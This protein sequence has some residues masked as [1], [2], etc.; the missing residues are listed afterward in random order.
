MQ[1]PESALPE[2]LETTNAS[3][4]VSPEG[5]VKL[6]PD[7]GSP[8]DVIA[9][10]TLTPPNIGAAPSD[11]ATDVLVPEELQAPTI[12]EIG[13]GTPDPVGEVAPP[14]GWVPN[15]Q[16]DGS[17]EVLETIRSDCSRARHFSGKCNRYPDRL[18]D[19]EYQTRVEQGL[20]IGDGSKESKQEKD[21]LR[22]IFL[23]FAEANG[24]ESAQH[25]LDTIIAAME[26]FNKEKKVDILH[27]LTVSLATQ[28]MSGDDINTLY[29]KALRINA[30]HEKMDTAA[31]TGRRSAENSRNEHMRE[32][33]K[34]IPDMDYSDELNVYVQALG[35]SL[36]Q[37]FVPGYDILEN[38]DG[39]DHWGNY[40]GTPTT[41]DYVLESIAFVPVVGI[42][43]KLGKGAKPLL[44]IL[45]KAG[46][47]CKAHSF[48]ES[49]PVATASGLLAIG[50][51]EEQDVLQVY[52]YDEETDKVALFDITAFHVHDDPVTIDLTVDFDLTDDQPGELIETTP[53]HPFY[54]LGGWID[55]EDLEV[56]M[57]LSTFEGT[58][59]VHSSTVT[60]VERIEETQT[61]YNLTVDTAHTFFVGEGE[62]LVH[63]C[64]IPGFSRNVVGTSINGPT[65]G[66][67]IAGSS[68]YLNWVNTTGRYPSVLTTNPQSLIDDFHAGKGVVVSDTPGAKSAVVRFDRPIGNI[69]DPNTGNVLVEGTHYGAVKYGSRLHITPV[70]WSTP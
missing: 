36:A 43:G 7:V 48:S 65:Q 66:K 55:A 17:V 10:G 13:S 62:W 37:L 56:G 5:D 24:V 67:H 20:D 16:E 53:E 23:G 49:T 29:E 41:G 59:L 15:G 32:F 50:T 6:P 47:V 33:R 54:V 57:P 52:G 18:S 51:L 4:V 9:P 46:K 35:I 42:L 22:G 3:E 44:N 61:M 68:E 21:K 34:V 63:N 64:D 31:A 19:E 8:T 69:I 14:E 12:P 2:S 1:A 11:S 26:S 45:K 40:M 28:A 60:S 25:K 70:N 30:K 39:Y 38:Q 27:D 58:T